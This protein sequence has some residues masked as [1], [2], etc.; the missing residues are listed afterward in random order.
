MIAVIETCCRMLPEIADRGEGRAGEARRTR[1]GTAG[2]GTARCC[3]AGRA[4]SA[5]RRGTRRRAGWRRSVRGVHVGCSS[6]GCEQPVL[7]DRSRSANSRAIC[8]PSHHQDPVG[9]RQHRLRLGRD[10][11]RRR[12]PCVS[13]SRARSAPRRPWRR[14][15]CRGSARSAPAPAAVGEPA[16]P[17]PPSAGCRRKACPAA[18]GIGRADAQ[19]LDV[20]LAR[21]RARAPASASSARCARG[22]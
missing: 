12:S 15:P 2:S 21:S 22:C 10:A 20:A 3:A 7:A 19:R 17:A 16:R 4:A 1:P 6:R 11:R 5:S 8:A 18:F 13:Q 14:H 9:Q